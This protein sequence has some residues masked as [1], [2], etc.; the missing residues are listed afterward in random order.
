MTQTKPVCDARS[1]GSESGSQEQNADCPAG[2][3]P[4]VQGGGAPGRRGRT[5]QGWWLLVRVGVAGGRRPRGR[6]LRGRCQH[7]GHAATPAPVSVAQLEGVCMARACVSALG[8]VWVLAALVQLS[9]GLGGWAGRRVFCLPS[10]REQ[11]SGPC[12]LGALCCW[13]PPATLG[14]LGSAWRL[15]ELRWGQGGACAA[16]R[17][18]L[19]DASPG[20]LCRW[21]PLVPL[22]PLH[23]PWSFC[24]SRESVWAPRSLGPAPARCGDEGERAPGCEQVAFI[25]VTAQ[26]LESGPFKDRSLPFSQSSG[27]LYLFPEAPV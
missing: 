27:I 11:P 4:E 17:A 9:G 5:S 16:G 15:V 1:R 10:L 23:P 14:A 18:F 21:H 13:T 8:S 3:R 25:S 7:A 6:A 22:L 26:L 20:S 24:L 12:D 19:P 2:G